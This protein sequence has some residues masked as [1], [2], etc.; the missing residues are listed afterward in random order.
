[1]SRPS[2]LIFAVSHT[3]VA[4]RPGFKPAFLH[5]WLSI[6]SQVAAAV[7]TASSC[8]I[9]CRGWASTLFRHH[10]A[11]AVP[12]IF[13]QYFS[14]DIQDLYKPWEKDRNSMT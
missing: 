10:L 5:K 2:E 1:M 14:L 7:A 4:M 12:S 11:I 3:Q 9:S 13:H 8:A 6:G